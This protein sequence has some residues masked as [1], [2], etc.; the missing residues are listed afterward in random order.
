MSRIFEFLQ[1]SDGGFSST[2]LISLLAYLTVFSVWAYLSVKGGAMI[3]I[4]PTMLGILGIVAAQ[5]VTQKFA[6]KK[7]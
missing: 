4:H 7:E 5:K 3:D 6:E 2:R 1:E